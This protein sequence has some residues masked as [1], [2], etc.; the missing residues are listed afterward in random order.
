MVYT[1]HSRGTKAQASIEY[2][3]V[4]ALLLL[5]LGPILYFG[6]RDLVTKNSVAQASAVV[7]QIASTADQVRAQGQGSRLVIQIR[8]PEN[9]ESASDSGREVMLKVRTAGGGL[10]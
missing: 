6:Y 3:T 1:L 8:M 2:V 4:I 5:A 10:R 7:K 9:V